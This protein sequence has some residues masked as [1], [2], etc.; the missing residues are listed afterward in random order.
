[1]LLAEHSI[2]YVSFVQVTMLFLDN[3]LR[4]II[5]FFY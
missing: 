4:T 3:V 2:F 5:L 1:M